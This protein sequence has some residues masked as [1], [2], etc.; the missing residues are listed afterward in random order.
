MKAR[1]TRIILC[2][3][4]MLIVG[5]IGDEL[6]LIEAAFTLMDNLREG[7]SVTEDDGLSLLE[8]PGVI[9]EVGARILYVLTGRDDLGWNNARSNGLPYCVNKTE[10][11]EYLN[12]K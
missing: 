11:L 4:A 7:Q 9:A 8:Y 5:L 10:W 1:F 2:L 3:T 6:E 12:R